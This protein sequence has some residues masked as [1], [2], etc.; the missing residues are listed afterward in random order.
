MLKG[1]IEAQ[2]LN[3]S[4]PPNNIGIL[5]SNMLLRGSSPLLISNYHSES[6]YLSEAI[7]VIISAEFLSFHN[8]KRRLI[9]G[10]K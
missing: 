1:H 9:S 7:F 6:S 8:F 2:N 3:Y 5:S 10:I 4:Q